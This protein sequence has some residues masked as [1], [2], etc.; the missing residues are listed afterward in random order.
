[1]NQ[2]R[3]GLREK[4]FVAMAAVGMAM[5]G[6]G[7][8]LLRSAPALA[9]ESAGFAVDRF[10]PASAGS[11]WFSLESLDFRGRLRPAGSLT[12]DWAHRPLVVDDENGNETSVLLKEQLILHIGAAVNL[13][14]RVRVGLNLPIS[15]YQTGQG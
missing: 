6:P 2:P 15:V 1:M 9:Q 13:F 8:G 10:E 14:E 7:V 3:S 11:D 5:L 4:S 12:L